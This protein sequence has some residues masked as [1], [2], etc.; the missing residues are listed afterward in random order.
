MCDLIYYV[1]MWLSVNQEGIMLVFVLFLFTSASDLILPEKHNLFCDFNRQ[2]ILDYMAHFHKNCDEY[3]RYL[4]HF[5]WW[6]CGQSQERVF[7]WFSSSVLSPGCY[8]TVKTS[9]DQQQ[10]TPHKVLEEWSSHLCFMAV[11]S[12]SSRSSKFHW[13]IFF[14]LLQRVQKPDLKSWSSG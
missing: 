7:W 9:C 1:I 4:C 13:W 12:F 10:T 14:S 11:T 2:K 3:A 5:M 6:T 8:L